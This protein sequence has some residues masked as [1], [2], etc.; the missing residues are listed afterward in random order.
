MN[1]IIFLG[2]SY[3]WGEGLELFIEKD[4]W[5]KQ[6]KKISNYD[7]LIKVKD[8]ESET[9]REQNRFASIVAKHFEMVEV[10]NRKNGG[11]LSDNF[12]LLEHFEKK[13]GMS[14]V[15]AIIVQLSHFYRT[16]IHL[17]S[18]CKCTFCKTLPDYPIS[19]II[20]DIVENNSNDFNKNMILN[21]FKKTE[22]DVEFM[23][24]FWKWVNWIERFCYDL[25]EFKLKKYEDMGIPVLF[26]D[27]W[28]VED[29][30]VHTRKYIVDRIIPLIGDDGKLY[31]KWVDF[32]KSFDGTFCINDYFKNTNNHHPSLRTH[33]YIAKSIIKKLEEI[34]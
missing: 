11:S 17:T 6:R 14:S 10:V 28:D 3:T 19:S 2:D 20:H 18:N 34:L 22:I 7:D 9:F 25:L 23:D 21:S 26:I 30:Y 16:P 24:W 31:K 8:E 1:H 15:N 32:E 5:I 12:K 33:Q 4:K 13:T 29:S 27:S